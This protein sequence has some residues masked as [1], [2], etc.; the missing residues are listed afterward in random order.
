MKKDL[1]NKLIA[2]INKPG[3]KPARFNILARKLDLKSSDFSAFKQ[4]IKE[5]V[6]Q[7]RIE[8]SKKDEIRPL[9]PHGT[10]TGIFRKAAGGFGFVRPQGTAEPGM[11]PAADIFIPERFVRNAISGDEVL[12]RIMKKPQRG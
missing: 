6:R 9:Q 11:P 5:L 4:L 10:I 3:Y 1:E 2:L 7:G 8:L 12:V